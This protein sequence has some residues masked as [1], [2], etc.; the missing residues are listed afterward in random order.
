[1]NG[2]SNKKRRLVDKCV[3]CKRMGI[4]FLEREKKNN[5]VAFFS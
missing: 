3:K 4:F 1:M 2:A 5:V